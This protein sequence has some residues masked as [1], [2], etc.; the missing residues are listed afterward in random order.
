MG[1]IRKVIFLIIILASLVSIFSYCG[2]KD[3][4][5]N[6]I[7][8]RE[9]YSMEYL[10]KLE[11][12]DVIINMNAIYED[13]L[14]NGWYIDRIT[15]D[16]NE[17]TISLYKLKIKLHLYEIIEDKDDLSVEDIIKLSSMDYAN[18]NPEKNNQFDMLYKWCRYSNDDECGNA[19]YN[20]YRYGIRSGFEI[21]KKKNNKNFKDKE[22]LQLTS[23]EI[24][25]LEDWIK[26]NPD[27]DLAKEDY[28]YNFLL[29]ILDVDN[30]PDASAANNRVYTMS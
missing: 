22:L 21:Y 18:S 24:F 17:T 20:F 23:E 14:D 16:D 29:K 2:L 11:K 10:K 7:S 25:E 28:N 5:Q 26:E 15:L 9:S 3:Y 30:V 8:E 12:I 6:N 1:K 19:K 27:Y 13:Y 4:K